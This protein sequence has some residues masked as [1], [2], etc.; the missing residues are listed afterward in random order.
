[1]SAPGA[2]TA[3]LFV[4]T[5]CRRYG[6]VPLGGSLGMTERRLRERKKEIRLALQKHSVDSEVAELQRED[7]T[8]AEALAGVARAL[9]MNTGTKR[10]ET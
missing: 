2:T 5:D 4:R 6:S 3:A 8:I 1:M 7:Q 10:I 9:Q